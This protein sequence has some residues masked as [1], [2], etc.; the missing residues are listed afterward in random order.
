MAL[1]PGALGEDRGSIARSTENAGTEASS[2]S[3]FS[4]AHAWISQRSFNGH[5]AAALPPKG[6]PGIFLRA[7]FGNGE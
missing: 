1:S 7:H 6:Q 2:F 4:P 5:R 3:N